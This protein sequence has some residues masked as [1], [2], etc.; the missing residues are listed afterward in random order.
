[1]S[2][3]RW[4]ARWG[5]GAGDGHAPAEGEGNGQGAAAKVGSLLAE[6][7]KAKGLEKLYFDRFSGSH[8]Y[9]Y[10]GRVKSLV[11]AIREGGITV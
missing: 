6:R 2:R 10:H 8:K 9:L 7:A 3:V 4:R 11:E 5:A 1:M